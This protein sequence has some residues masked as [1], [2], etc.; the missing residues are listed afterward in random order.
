MAEIPNKDDEATWPN[1]EKHPDE[2]A[3]Y[4]DMD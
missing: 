3:D 2:E 1:C 4:F